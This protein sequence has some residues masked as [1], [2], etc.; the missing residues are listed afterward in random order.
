MKEGLRGFPE[1]GG[2]QAGWVKTIFPF[3]FG[4]EKVLICS[5]D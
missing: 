4:L 3:F 1:N 5:D 2:L